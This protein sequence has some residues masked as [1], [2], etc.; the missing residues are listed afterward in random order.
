MSRAE[1]ESKT[2]EISDFAA[3]PDGFIDMPVRTYSSGMYGRVAFS[4][5]VNMTPDILLLDEALSA[6]DA[7]FKEKSFNRMRELC[8]EARTIVIVSHALQTV[9][10][11]CDS[12]IWLHKGT[13]LSKGNPEAIVDEYLKFLKVGTL[14]SN[15]EDM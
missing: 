6:G 12:A 5:A 1:I 2:E 3:L 7:A 13:M 15:L 14:P 11:L 4:V 10:D 8:A 9:N